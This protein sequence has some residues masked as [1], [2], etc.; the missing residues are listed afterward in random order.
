M[1]KILP[2]FLCALATTAGADTWIRC[3]DSVDVAQGA[4]TGPVTLV[5]IDDRIARVVADHPEVDGG[6]E[7]I[8]LSGLTCLPGLMD[9]HTHL[10]SESSPTS[11]MEEFT[12]NEADVA[13]RSTVFARRTLDAGFT[14]VRNV[15]DSYNA[16]IALRNAIDRDLVSGP[17]I[18]TSGKSLATTGGHADPTNG[19]RSSLRDSPA[20][21]R[22]GTAESRRS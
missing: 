22:S 21:T 15:G 20:R 11:Y 16:S 12:L 18:F 19:W 1:R 4:L 3:G 5:V 10:T 13:F 17:R 9:M 6:A 2:A 8:D 14:T 7:L